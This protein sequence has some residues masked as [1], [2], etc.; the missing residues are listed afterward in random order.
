MDSIRLFSASSSARLK[1]T[2]IKSLLQCNS[3]EKWFMSLIQ[4][5]NHPSYST[6]S[7]NL[8]IEKLN[9]TDLLYLNNLFVNLKYVDFI[10][11]LYFFKTKPHFLC[12]NNCSVEQLLAIK[13]KLSCLYIFIELIQKSTSKV[14]TQ[15]GLV[16]NQDY[17]FHGEEI[18]DGIEVS[19]FLSYRSV[20]LS[21]LDNYKWYT[22]IVSEIAPSESAVNQL[23]KVYTFW[24]NPSYLVDIAIFFRQKSFENKLNLSNYMLKIFKSLSTTTCLSLYGHF[25]NNHTVKFLR[26]LKATYLSRNNLPFL[27]CSKIQI[28]AVKHVF[29]I[30][31]SIMQAVRTALIKRHIKTQNY[32]YMR[33]S[34]KEVL[35]GK[36]NCQ[37]IER[38]LTFY[39]P[40]ILQKNKSLNELFFMLEK[41]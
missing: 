31:N 12:V 11:S 4:L 35:S 34:P 33:I 36:R 1:N 41:D 40:R 30:I 26:L 10:N 37:A 38:I 2:S 6:S 28:K 3:I 7:I 9:T 16:E 15:R 23:L 19:I 13:N 21:V 5:A 27:P 20:I 17:L 22:P 39:C 14:I 24:F 32:R 8:Q 18:Q 29:F 25:A